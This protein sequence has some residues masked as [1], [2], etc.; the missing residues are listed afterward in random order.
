MSAKSDPPALHTNPT[1]SSAIEEDS[2]YP[3]VCSAVANIDD[4]DMPVNTV[5]AWVIGIL[6]TILISGSSQFF[7]L[8]IPS[9]SISSFV[10]I[11]LSLPMGRLW[12]RVLPKWKIFGIRLNLAAPFS[13]KEHVFL[14]IMAGVSPNAAYAIDVIAAQRVYFGQ[15]YS[16]GYQWMLVMS[17]QLIGFAFG[18][19]MHRVLVEPP[20]MI[21][22]GTL[23]ICTLF[24]TLNSQTYQGA[25][26]HRGISRERFFA[27]V[28]LGSFFWYFFPGYL[29]QALSYFS[30]VCWIAPDNVVVNQLFGYVNGLGMSGITFD[31]TQVSYI[32]NPL[33]TPWWVEANVVAGFL[34]FFW[35]LTPILYYTNTW[36]AKYMPISP[37]TPTPFDNTGN[38]YNVTA[39]LNA[40]STFNIT[41]YEEYSPMLVPAAY[42]VSSGLGFAAITATFT[43]V[44]LFFRNEIWMQMRQPKSKETDVHARLMS[45][46]RQ[47]P[48]WWY[49]IIFIGMFAL[50]IAAIQL[51]PTQ[52]PVWGFIVSLL[53]AFV[54][55]IPIGMIQAIT[56]VQFSTSTIAALVAGYAFPG[57]P[58]ALVMFNGWASVTLAQGLQYASDLKIGHYMKIRPRALFFA[59]V[60]G[61]AVAGT[62]QLAVQ[63]W[64]FSNIP[65]ICTPMQ[66]DGFTCPYTQ[67]LG[68][69]SVMWG[70]IGPER[71]YSVGQ[72]YNALLW[73][74]LIGVLCPLITW[75]ISIKWPNRFV[76]YVNF[77]V[78]FIGASY[79]PPANGVNYI[80]WGVV[81]F[82]FQYV[83]RRKYFEWWRKYN[84]I[85]GSALD[86]GV[87]LSALVIFFCLEYPRNGLIGANSIGTWW[88]N[89][90]FLKNADAKG[91]PLLT[92][93]GSFGPA[94]W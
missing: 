73:F 12:A 23:P 9:V 82:I 42:A 6:W 74:F 59:Q 79:V 16:F 55:M 29:F 27:Y 32:S 54:C 70:A 89:T 2:R 48:E 68:I 10:V 60:V 63:A 31:W 25:G 90:V 4:P 34:F 78:I 61:T 77:P 71:R 22:P 41:A 85:L 47:V 88:G 58:I 91:L 36:Y 80:P 66:K 51:S 11:L 53:I 69:S 49:L 7:V 17:T 37:R 87:A 64:M 8:R 20:S 67:L 39:I 38:I 28:C 50:G 65:D 18:G 72:T 81:G 75:I 94:S 1:T 35:F 57:R 13:I 3:E 15:V 14:S 76:G 43:H 5:R 19:V 56:D 62:V 93:N 46:Y 33:A 83:V 45:N 40:D 84:Y 24:N 21:W 26:D 30:W 92:T 44:I 52:L 86:T